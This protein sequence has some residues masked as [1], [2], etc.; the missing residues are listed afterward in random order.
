MGAFLRGWVAARTLAGRLVRRG[1]RTVLTTPATAR[2]GNLLYFWLHCHRMGRL[3]RDVR[4]L[5]VPGCRPWLDIWPGLAA[6]FVVA[7][8]EVRR[9]DRRGDVPL[10][11]FQTW[12]ADYARAELEHFVRE[13]LLTPGFVSR[14]PAV[15]AGALTVNVRRG[16]YYSVPE[17]RERYAF[18]IESYVREAV[19]R[20]AGDADLSEVLIVSDDPAWCRQRLG[21]LT[22]VAPVRCVAGGPVE[23]LTTLAASRRLVLA[24]STFSYWGAH[25][26]SVVHG[27]DTRVVA[28]QFHSRHVDGGRSWQLDPRWDVVPGFFAGE[29]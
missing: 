25:L 26:S 11:H 20:V 17:Y 10:R 2:V 18:D 16:D 8:G 1:P 6:R 12:G 15:P 22:E 23:H 27:A 21:W 28:P 4:T 14:M 19:G 7:P 13:R 9:W 29:P 24:N 5:A 3:G